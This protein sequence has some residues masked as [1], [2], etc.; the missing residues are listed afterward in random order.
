[1]TSLLPQ[2]QLVATMATHWLCGKFDIESCDSVETVAQTGIGG[3]NRLAMVFEQNMT[4]LLPQRRLVPTWQ[5]TVF[6]EN[7]MLSHVTVLKQ[8]HKGA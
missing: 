4:S 6:V 8:R 7:L 2:Q 3:Q 5:T 1:M